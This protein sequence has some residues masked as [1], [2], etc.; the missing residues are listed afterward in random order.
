M[1]GRLLVAGALAAS[2]V[3]AA[4][5]HA[6]AAASPRCALRE[7]GVVAPAG[8]QRPLVRPGAIGVLLCRYRGLNPAATALRLR[9]SRRL[10]DRSEIASITT[11][12]DRL[13]REK[14]RIACPFDDGSAILATFAY[15]DGA[16]AVVRVG[17]RGCQTV[18][19]AHPP[20]RTAAT[21]PA[22]ARL[23]ARLERMVR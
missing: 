4:A 2:A 14:A 22:G 13:P 3:L 15:S 19:G 12:L 23:I 10:T 5:S 1:N 18:T 7:P 16:A 6:A 20:A 9:S 11:S 8:A 17:L 21:T